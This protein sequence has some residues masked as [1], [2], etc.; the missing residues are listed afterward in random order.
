MSN[1]TATKFLLGLP[2]SLHVIYTDLLAPP[3][4]IMDMIVSSLDLNSCNLSSM[5]FLVI[6]TIYLC[7]LISGS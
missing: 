1:H 5:E 6:S 4:G 2:T 7:D 3:S